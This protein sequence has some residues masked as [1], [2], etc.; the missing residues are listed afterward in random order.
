MPLIYGKTLHSIAQ[1]LEVAKASLLNYKDVYTP[2][3]EIY[4]FFK[5]EYSGIVNFMQ[6]INNIG[7]FCALLQRRVTYSI[8]YFKT[9]QDYMFLFNYCNYWL[10]DGC[11]YLYVPGS[12]TTMF[13]LLKRGCFASHVAHPE[14]HPLKESGSPHSPID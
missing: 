13:F 10:T 8:S 1:D 3:D 11:P 5:I 4:S 14:Q 9:A 12:P 6:L 7:Y 2:A